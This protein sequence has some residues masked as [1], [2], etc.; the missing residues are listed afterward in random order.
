MPFSSRLLSS[1]MV[2]RYVC[3]LLST[4]ISILFLIDLTALLDGW[5]VGPFSDGIWI[6][7]IAN[8]VLCGLWQCPGL[9]NLGGY[10]AFNVVRGLTVLKVIILLIMTLLV[11][12][13]FFYTS[14]TSDDCNFWLFIVSL[15]RVALTIIQI[16]IFLL[17]YIPMTNGKVV[18]V[19]WAAPDKI[20]YGMLAEMV[21]LMLSGYLL[22]CPPC[23]EKIGE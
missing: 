7:N 9:S 15:T 23:R 18:A 8:R 16:S 10:W 4:I 11:T 14:S 21:A 20:I 2:P 3:V 5:E 1:E 19:M 6:N 12:L 22:A 13:V 17:V